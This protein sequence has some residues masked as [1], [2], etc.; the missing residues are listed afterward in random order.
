M[1][2]VREGYIVEM[3]GGDQADFLREHLDSFGDRHCFNVAELGVGLNPNARLT[4][5]MLEDEGVMGT[6]PYRYRYEP[7]PRRGDRG[8]NALRLD[9]VG[10]DHHG[11][12]PD[13][14]A[15]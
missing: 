13:R 4:G 10:A 15:R 9:H 5:E 2:V 8:S 11:R 3:T 6:I 14:A 1:C 7:H 12:W